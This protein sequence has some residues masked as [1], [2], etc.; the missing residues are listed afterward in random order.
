MY[1]FASYQ[2]RLF[3]SQLTEKFKE[4]IRYGPQKMA[5]RPFIFLE[6]EGLA[7]DILL[8]GLNYFNI[9]LGLTNI[10]LLSEGNCI[11]GAQDQ[12]DIRVRKIVLFFFSIT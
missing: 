12:D 4:K 2:S 6:A 5:F 3:I 1:W 7:L 11:C 9:Q 10:R 8:Q